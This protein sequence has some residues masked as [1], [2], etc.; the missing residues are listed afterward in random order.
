MSCRKF[1]CFSIAIGGHFRYN[2]KDNRVGVRIFLLHHFLRLKKRGVDGNY[3]EY[4][5]FFCTAVKNA[6]I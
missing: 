6:D 1:F 4:T 2:S 3:G 5:E